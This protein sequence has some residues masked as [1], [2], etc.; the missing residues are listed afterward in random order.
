MMDSEALAEMAAETP[1]VETLVYES[2]PPPTPSSGCGSL[3][4]S[5]LFSPRDFTWKAWMGDAW[6]MRG[7][8][9]G[10]AWEMCGRCVGDAWEMRGRCVGHAREM[11]AVATD[12]AESGAC[13]RGCLMGCLM[14]CLTYLV[15][16]LLELFR[17]WLSL[18]QN[19]CC[20]DHHQ[21][22]LFFAISLSKHR[23]LRRP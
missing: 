15:L 14:G 16:C 17:T 9:V 20:E 18:S 4:G 12:A 23:K 8:C 19:G 7:R 6:E 5:S 2:P 1:S 21:P 10:D 11:L 13:L 22:P 3:H